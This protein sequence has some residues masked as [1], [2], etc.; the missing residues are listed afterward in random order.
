[1]TIARIL[2]SIALAAA[3][4]VGAAACGSSSHKSTSATE[5]TAASESAPASQVQGQTDRT[6]SNPA[7]APKALAAAVIADKTGVAPGIKVTTSRYACIGT[8]AEAIM[9]SPGLDSVT[10]YFR[11]DS[12][13]WKVLDFGSAGMTAQN[14]GVP[15][16][17]FSQLNTKVLGVPD[18]NASAPAAAPAPQP[19]YSPPQYVPVP[20][21]QYIPA[22]PTPAS[23]WA[24][25]P[26]GSAYQN[27]PQQPINTGGFNYNS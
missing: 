26:E 11:N 14:T 1:M 7:C 8:Y 21:P 23:G 4:T 16:N 24:G 18:P 9:D 6:K 10:A 3:V 15:A 17:I 27:A 20:Q 25:D 12:G 2:G 19:Q 22:A 13:T 5:A